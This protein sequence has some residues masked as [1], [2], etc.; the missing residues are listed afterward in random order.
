MSFTFR[1]SYDRNL[2]SH[3]PFFRLSDLILVTFVVFLSFRS[4]SA[5]YFEKNRS[6]K[7]FL[8]CKNSHKQKKL[9]PHAQWGDSD[10]NESMDR[11]G[12]VQERIKPIPGKRYGTKKKGTADCHAVAHEAKDWEF[13]LNAA[14]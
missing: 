4:R 9:C 11:T 7:N 3:R 8:T 13:L 6:Q 5:Y 12:R 14:L 1:I 2:W 10:Y